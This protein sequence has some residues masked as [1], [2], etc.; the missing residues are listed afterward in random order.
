MKK[1]LL[2]VFAHPDDEAFGPSGTIA[3]YSEE[4][5]VYI[6]CVTDGYD[7]KRARPNLART[8]RSE[9]RESAKILGVEK[10]FFLN[11]GDGELRNNIYHQVAGE[12][13][14]IAKRIKPDTLLTFEPRGISG[15]IDHVFCSMV[16]S[17]VYQRLSFIKTLLYCCITRDRTK[18]IK[19]YF[20]YF[21]PGYKPEEIDLEVDVSEYWDK[22][23]KA[24]NVH[25]SQKKDAQRIIKS[26]E[27][28]P[29][30]EHFLVIRK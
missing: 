9:L 12:I 18:E 23:I 16:T 30:K 29:K 17:F 13:E 22:K 4:R 24:I 14:K 11:F 1:P 2:C 7:K 27:K 15:H 5:K 6:I 8:R 21:P 28:F 20:V 3:K 26:L 25:R 19:D 10:V